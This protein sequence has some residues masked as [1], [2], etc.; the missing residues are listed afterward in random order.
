[1]VER[2]LFADVH[3]VTRKSEADANNLASSVAALLVP[4]KH[5]SGGTAMMACGLTA[6][7]LAA[8][9]KESH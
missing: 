9:W 3:P 1:V 5:Y 2:T 7:V 8:G 4:V 6:C